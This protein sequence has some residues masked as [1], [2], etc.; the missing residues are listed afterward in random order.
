MTCIYPNRFYEHTYNG[1]NIH[2]DTCMIIMCLH[3]F[4]AFLHAVC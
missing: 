3:A 1:D 2:V 4:P